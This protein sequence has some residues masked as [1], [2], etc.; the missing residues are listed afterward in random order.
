[1][2]KLESLLSSSVERALSYPVDSFCAE[3][4]V[5]LP[6][7]TLT[8]QICTGGNQ[9]SYL[10]S[11]ILCREWFPFIPFYFFPVLLC[12]QKQYEATWAE[13]FSPMKMAGIYCI[14]TGTKF[15]LDISSWCLKKLPTD[16]FQRRKNKAYLFVHSEAVFA[17]EMSSEVG[18]Q[19]TVSPLSLTVWGD[20]SDL[21][22]QYLGVC[23]CHGWQWVIHA[24][25][26]WSRTRGFFWGIL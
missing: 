6:I 12:G 16:Q 19:L 26:V 18:L 21:S 2:G 10:S 7:L 20:A 25:D 5:R 17:L 14:L 24:Q 3:Q 11:L 4:L 8:I 23:C 15:L 22:E 1:M 9:Y 13:W